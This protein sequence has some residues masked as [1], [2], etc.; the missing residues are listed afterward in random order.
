V[1]EARAAFRLLLHPRMEGRLDMAIDQALTEAVESGRSAPV[2]R[3]YG[4][5]PPTLSLGRFQ[6]IKGLYRPEKLAQDGVTLVRRPTGGHAVLHDE[7][8]TYSVI[9]SKATIATQLGDSRK[10]T[11]YDFIARILLEGLARLGIHG[12]INASRQGDLRNPDC[13]R[14]SGE[15]E[16]TGDEGK[17]L[18]GSAQMTTR[19]AILQH[20]SIPLGNPGRRVFQYLVAEEPADSRDP[21]SLNEQTGRRLRFEEVQAC[22]AAA[23]RECLFTEESSLLAVEEEAADRILAEKFGND[24]WNLAY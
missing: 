7:E 22:F 13:F 19:T 17:K 11:V 5:F 6:R 15:F 1:S 21:S 4:F 12:N 3:L 9:L 8:L 18:I 2:V 20:G 24:E 14:S 10:R 23:F 16:I